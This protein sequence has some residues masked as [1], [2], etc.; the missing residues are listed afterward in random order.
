MTY[1]VKNYIPAG[2]K[3]LWQGKAARNTIP[4][5]V[6][7][8]A[9]K[10]IM[11]NGYTVDVIPTRAISHISTG[12]DVGALFVRLFTNGGTNDDLRFDNDTA[13]CTAFFNCLSERLE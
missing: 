3:V 2:E 11:S 1:S 4:C 10:L 13:A 7:V 12:G 6:V 8:T 9:K 5:E